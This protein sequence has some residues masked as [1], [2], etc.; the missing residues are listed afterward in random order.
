M[1]QVSKTM[2]ADTAAR[3]F[4]ASAVVMN[5]AL[6][7]SP[8]P[9]KENC[10]AKSTMKVFFISYLFVFLESIR[11]ESEFKV[12]VTKTQRAACKHS[13]LSC[14]ATLCNLYESRPLL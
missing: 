11:N 12:W 1:N 9:P 14:Y 13:V 7:Y 6:Y 5:A 2:A 4:I 8:E 10:G 3:K